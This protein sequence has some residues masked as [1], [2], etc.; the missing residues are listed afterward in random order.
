MSR[1]D[2]ECCSMECYSI[3]LDLQWTSKLGE[4]L[5]MKMKMNILIKGTFIAPSFRN[6]FLFSAI[7]TISAPFHSDSAS[8]HL[9]MCQKI[10]TLDDAIQLFDQMTQRQP[11]PSVVNFNQ[12]LQTVTKMKHYSCSIDLFKQMTAIGFPVSVYTV[13]IVI[14]CF[15]QMSCTREGFA[16][17][18][19]GFKRGVL[20]NVI[21]FSTLLNGL[22]LEDRVHEAERLFK[23]LIK[24]KLCKPDVVMYSTM[25]KGLCKVGINDTAIGLL[26]LMDERGCKPNVM[27]YSTIIDS[28]CKD[29]MIDDALKLFN[30][31]I[32]H[33]GI[34]PDVVTYNSLISGLC[35]QGRWDDASKMLRGMEYERISPDVITYNILV[36][37][38]CKEGMAEDAEAVLNIMVER[39]KVPDLVTYNSLI[40]GFCLRGETKKAK[41]IFDL[42]RIRGLVPDVVTYN[43]LLNGYCKN[44]EIDEALLLFNELT[45]KGTK[46]NVVTYNTLLQGLFLVGRCKDARELF[47]EM[48]AHNHISPDTFTY[49]IVLQGLCNNRQVDKALSLFRLMGDSEL[50]LDIVL[51][52]ILID[53]TGKCGKPDIAKALFNEISTKG[54]NPNVRTYNVMIGCF[55][56]VG[57]VREAERLFLQMEERGC[58]RDC[59][60]YNVILQG[61]LKNEQHDTIKMLLEEMEGQGFSVDASTCSMLLDH[62]SSGPLDGSLLKL[63]GKLVPKEAKEALDDAL[64]LFDQMTQRQPLPSVVKFNQLLT[65]VAKMKHYSCSIHLFKQMT[66]IGVP[67]PF[68]TTIVIKCFCQMSCTREGFAI[69]GYGFKHGVLPNVITFNTLLNGL[70]LEDR[71]FEAERLFKKLIKER[72][73]EPDV[74]TY[75]TMIKGL[76]KFGINDTAIALLILMDERGCKPDVMTYSTIIDSLCKNK[77][78]DDALKLFNEMILNKGILPNHSVRDKA[79]SQGPRFLPGEAKNNRPS[80]QSWQMMMKLL[81]VLSFK[82]PNFSFSKLASEIPSSLTIIAPFHSNSTSNR[83]SSL[84]EKITKLDDALQLFDQMSQKQPLPS[85]VK[86]NQLLTVVAKMRHYSCSIHLFKQMVAIR[87]PVD[88]YTFNIVIKCC[89]QMSCTRDGFSVVAYGFRRGVVPDVFT[90]STLLNGLILEDRILE[91]E[92]LFKKLIKRKL[93]EPNVVMYS[94]MIKG[95]CKV[96]INDMAIALL[97]LM[98]EKGCKPNVMTYSTIIDSLCKDEMVDDAVKLFHEMIIHKRILP[99]V[100]TYNSLIRGLCNLSRWDDAVKMLREMEDERI[101]PDVITYTILVDALC[102]EGMAE[103]AEAVLNIMVERG[104]VP[105]LV[106]YNSLI[107]GYGLRG[108]MKKAKEIYDMIRIRGLVPDVVTYNSLLNGYCKKLEID[109]ALLLFNELTEKGMKPDVVTYNTMLQGLFRVGRCKDAHELFNEMQ[110]HIHIPRDA[111]TYRIVLEGLCANHQVDEALSLFRLMSEKKLSFDIVVYNILFDGASKCGKLNIAKVPFN[112]LCARGLHP[113]VW[114]YNAMICGF[115]REGLVRESKELFQKMAEVGCVPDR[116]TYNILLRGLLKNGQHDTIKMLLEEMDGK[117]FSIDASTCSMLIDHISSGSLDN[118][119]LKLIG[120]LVPKEGKEAACLESI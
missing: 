17:V 14:K 58:P 26:R 106:T 71:V 67:V 82:N 19:Y 105:N 63:I 120:R 64:Q 20:P 97:R 103:N 16:I 113:D 101:S 119:L 88:L 112:D 45:E 78:V 118:S 89:C 93:C 39:G 49:G 43:S 51:Y 87:A 85:V 35:N 75:T 1:A 86:F 116:V 72:L 83:K 99:D 100:V 80:M 77:M 69:V 115:C 95:L 79:R 61:L 23:K 50:N 5:Q 92:R 28:L 76:C 90:F 70:V 62:I 42:I 114:T 52:N 81:K 4:K 40:D 33:K 66:A 60:T 107:D 31:M 27:T 8:N 7:Q 6:P 102:K 74:S 57:L 44:L 10:S 68:T 98:N 22:I 41:E 32:L 18:G 56:G 48:R 36:D 59:V 91:A 47:N 55:C 25:I 53:G 109:E 9:S 94:T 65:A 54:L 30:E 110:A 12:L 96:G 24:G 38:L 117:G 73:C 13:N 21:T 104:K 46:P 34:L 3:E 111:F 15:C 108:E 2:M 37:A 29:K 84:F 11:L